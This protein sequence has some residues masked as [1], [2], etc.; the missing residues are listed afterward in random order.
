MTEQTHARLGSA[1]VVFLGI[2]DVAG[3]VERRI[4]E[5]IQEVDSVEQIR[6]VAPDI[7]GDWGES[8]WRH[9]APDLTDEHKIG[10]TADLF[11]QHLSAAY[12]T[13]RLREHSLSL[14][15]DTRLVAE[16]E[17]AIT[18]LLV[19]HPLAI[20]QWARGV[21]INPRVG[22][23]VLKSPELGKALVALGRLAGDSATLDYEGVF[24]TASGPVDILVAT[25]TVPTRRLADA[26]EAKSHERASRGE[27][28]PLFLIAGGVG[29]LSQS[30]A[31]P[32]SI[33]GELASSD[34]I[35]GPLA[36]TPNIRHA[37]EVLAS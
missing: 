11:M 7:R 12:I 27:T 32:R 33:L 34:I 14:Q 35:D 20:L 23:P 26:A 15:S 36:H 19:A 17:A 24:R 8:Q 25:Q 6:V 2:G 13:G 18:G 21:D 16:L 30:D 29:P 31:L 5:A 22:E 4:N 37:D 9:V 10:A 3:Y 1:V 28:P